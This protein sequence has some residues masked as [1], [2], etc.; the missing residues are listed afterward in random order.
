MVA[1]RRK[2]DAAQ[3]ARGRGR[4]GRA[5]GEGRSDVP[6][7]ARKA[8]TGPWPLPSEQR[9]QCL[10]CSETCNGQRDGALST[11]VQCTHCDR[12]WH[13]ACL[14]LEGAQTHT[15]IWY[16]EKC[17]QAYWQGFEDGRGEAATPSVVVRP[18]NIALRPAPSP[19]FVAPRMGASRQRSNTTSA[20]ATT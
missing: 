7:V 19:C 20:A 9:W 16:C 11:R 2:E 13:T 12:Q 15:G 18:V 10:G 14:D 6:R 5:R 8:G 4:S 3:G 17:S 1:G